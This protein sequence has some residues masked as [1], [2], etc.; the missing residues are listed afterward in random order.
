M[1]IVLA[2]HTYCDVEGGDHVEG[3]GEYC[4][5]SLHRGLIQAVISG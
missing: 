2:S 4:A 1:A 5:H 3:R